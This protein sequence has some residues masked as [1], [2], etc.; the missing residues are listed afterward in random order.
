MSNPVNASAFAAEVSLED[1]LGMR[2]LY[3][4]EMD[5]QVVH[6]SWHARGWT[7]MYLLSLGGEVAGYGAVGGAPRDT[8]D[9]IKEFFLLP[10]RRGD[11]LAL[12]RT[13][14]AASGAQRI[15]AQTNDTCL[16]LMLCDFATDISSERILFSGGVHTA[17]AAP[18]QGLRFRE[19]TD[20]DRRTVFDHTHEPVGEWG[21]DHEG[22]ILATGGLAFHYNP[23][24]ADIYMEVDVRHHRRGLGSYL[25]Q[26]LRRLCDERGYRP[27][28][29]CHHSNLA[30]RRALE[31]GGM[32][33]C[34]RIMEGRLTPSG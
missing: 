1:V 29:R 17:L 3:R 19:L 34:A 10:E 15:E 2:E 9:T 32:V 16:F 18:I 22:S 7:R 23:P 12:F 6:D 20:A 4:R 21:L 27:A 14:V 13:L 33:P 31:R 11:A 26:E 25:V 8:K 28:A 5:A 24:Y 30:S